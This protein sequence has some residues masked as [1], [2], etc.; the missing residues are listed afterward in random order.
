MFFHY[1]VYVVNVLAVFSVVSI[2]LLLLSF[3]LDLSLLVFATDTKFFQ[4]SPASLIP[5][6]NLNHIL[7]IMIVILDVI[8]NS[9]SI[10]SNNKLGN[11]YFTF[12]QNCCMFMIVYR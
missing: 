6:Q 9:I 4:Y 2:L 10:D 8:N 7:D 12:F 5:A 1:A 11:K 3:L